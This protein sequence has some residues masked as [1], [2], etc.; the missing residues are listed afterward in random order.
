MSALIFSP[1]HT[2]RMG[3]LNNRVTWY[4]LDIVME[5]RSPH[6][7]FKDALIESRLQPN[8]FHTMMYPHEDY[9]APWGSALIFRLFRVP[10]HRFP[11]V[12]AVN[13]PRQDPMPP[14]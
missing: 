8:I 9:G 10:L 14:L 1:F 4:L 3:L 11:A 7:K 2:S 6:D 13:A 12:R 5:G